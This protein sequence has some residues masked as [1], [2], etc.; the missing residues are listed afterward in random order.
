LRNEH[1]NLLLSEA[2][3]AADRYFYRIVCELCNNEPE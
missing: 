1:E 3:P 2:F